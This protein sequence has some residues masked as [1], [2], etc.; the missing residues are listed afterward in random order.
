MN[1]IKVRNVKV[2]S[3]LKI[4]GIVIFP[5]ILFA[6][7]EPSKE[8]QNHERIHCEQIKRDGLIIFYTRYVFEYFKSR[9][10]G[11]SHDRAYK[12]ISYEKEAYLHQQNFLYQIASSK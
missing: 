9:K 2:L 7:G 11:L 8:I 1:F 6:S 10:N 5:F 3:F 12:G 4:E